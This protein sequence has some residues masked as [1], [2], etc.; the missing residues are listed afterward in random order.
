MRLKEGKVAT[1]ALTERDDDAETQAPVENAADV[2]D[3][4]SDEE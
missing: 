1:V 3:E 4:P 2:V